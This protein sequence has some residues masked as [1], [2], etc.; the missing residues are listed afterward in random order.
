MIN[1]DSIGL[2]H[3]EVWV[4]R[5]DKTLVGWAAALAKLQNHKITEVDVDRVG[6]TDSSSF[7]DKKIP[8]IT[9]HSLTP[10]NFRV[11]HSSR[12]VLSAV[13][14]EN[15]YATYKFLTGYVALVDAKADKSLRA[16]K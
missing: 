4:T 8:A 9:F 10:E 5:A 12:D 6:D 11:L 3:T 15:L 16:R 2:E 1:I 7:L 14:R 13:N